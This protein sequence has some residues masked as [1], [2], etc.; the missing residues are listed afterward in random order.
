MLFHPRVNTVAIDTARQSLSTANNAQMHLYAPDEYYAAER[1]WNE[2][3]CE[4]REQN[5]H[6]FLVRNYHA[7]EKLAG[8]V[9]SLAKL[10]LQSGTLYHDSI[11]TKAYEESAFLKHSL[12]NLNRSFH[13][14]PKCHL[15][16]KQ[17]SEC[18][19]NTLQ[20]NEALSRS[21]Y[22]DA[23]AHFK[24]GLELISDA[25]TTLNHTMNQYISQKPQWEAWGVQTIN[26]SKVNHQTA[27]IIEKLSHKLFFFKNG[28]MIMTLPVELGRNWLG[29][30]SRQGDKATPEGYY[31][32]IEKKAQR[33]TSY[34]KALV[35]N[36]PSA[37]DIATVIS[38]KGK[39]YKK[40]IASLGGNIEI[41]GGGGKGCDWTDGSIALRDDDIDKIFHQVSLG[42]PVTI[43]GITG[44]K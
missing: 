36:Y 16:Q 10:S 18:Q 11:R 21:A 7:T 8:I 34:Y 6:F 15:L 13:T 9:D 12:D 29:N 22:L 33:N 30:K 41:H 28:S 38:E 37:R 43:V 42:T 20:G 4:W 24:R 3:L 35:I 5:Q 25:S 32:I 26:K 2:L 40:R 39:C 44:L 1:N 14:L 17:I 27:I 31:H 19:L 23:R